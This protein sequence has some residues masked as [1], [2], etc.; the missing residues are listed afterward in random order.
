MLIVSQVSVL[1]TDA[2][3]LPRGTF[4]M[5]RALTDDLIG[6]LADITQQSFTIHLVDQ[7]GNDPG[8]AAL[9]PV[10]D[11]LAHDAI[12]RVERKG[13]LWLKNAAGEPVAMLEVALSE[14]IYRDNRMNSETVL[15]L[16]LATLTM[17][18]VRIALQLLVLNPLHVIR[19][20]LKTIRESAN[21]SLR[22]HN[23]RRDEVGGLS[24]ECDSLVDYVKAQEEYLLA[25]N[26]DL[27]RKSLEDGL[28]EVANRRHFDVKIELLCR[29]FAQKRVPIFVVLVDVDCFKAYND[30]Y[31]H[32]K[33]DETLKAIA[34]TLLKNVRVN[35]DMVARYGGEE[36]VVLLTETDIAG[37]KVVCEKLLQAVRMLNIPHEDSGASAR[38]TVSMGVAG[39]TPK[40]DDA[41]ALL[42]AADKALYE[43]KAAGR[44]CVQYHIRDDSISR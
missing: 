38:V 9:A 41:L 23:T 28:T 10:L 4:V 43:A 32:L 37:V 24:R 44:D 22:L 34:E 36:F 25:I 29:A 19:T 33:G 30:K 12:H 7:V 20:H 17:L 11:K 16:I 15:V 5:V 39:W 27:T 26:Q 2:Q 6:V 42:A 14:A 13:Y 35:T 1:P 31:G 3:G 21:Y 18:I 40:E 8:L